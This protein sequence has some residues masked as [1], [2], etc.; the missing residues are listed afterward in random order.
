MTRVAVVRGGRSLERDISL[1]SGHHVAS[2]LRHTG[3]DV[4]EVDVDER[5]TSNFA[6]AD[7]AFIALHGRDGEDGTI[8]SILEALTMPYTGSDPLACQLCFDKP[9]AKGLLHRA[10][11]STPD[12]YVVSAEGVRRMGAGAALREAAARI[13]FPIVVKPA[14][15]GSALGLA[16]VRAPEELSSAVMAA[17]NYGDRVMLERFVS[18][19]ELA[20]GVVTDGAGQLRAL[21]PVE[22]KTSSGVFDFEARVTPGGA[23]FICPSDLTPEELDAVSAAAL[24]AAAILGV[25]DFARV[26][27]FVE[28]G[29]AVLEVNPCPGMTE[30]SLVP[31]A[32]VQDGVAFETFVGVVL[33]AALSRRGSARSVDR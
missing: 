16:V 18:G 26:D 22:I 9:V 24:E 15:Q 14:A 32:A 5:L 29:P 33:D 10:G 3:H 17:F 27:M 4:V 23:D 11:I 8:Q 6:D 30:T 21:P 20:V 7:V 25:R 19:R 2:A 28:E 13:G 31:L 12:W 1:R